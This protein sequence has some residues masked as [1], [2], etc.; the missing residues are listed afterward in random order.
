MGNAHGYG[1]RRIAHGSI[2]S[3][4]RLG[5]N[6]KLDSCDRVGVAAAAE[7]KTETGLLTHFRPAHIEE[8]IMTDPRTR[9]WTPALLFAGILA[10]ALSGGAM[11]LTLEVRSADAQPRGFPSGDPIPTQT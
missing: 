11:S 3:Q 1:T 8:P 10:I 7:P 9:I 2:V 4:F 6:E 5:T